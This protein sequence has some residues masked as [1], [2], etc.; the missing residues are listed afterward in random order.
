MGS[1]ADLENNVWRIFMGDDEDKEIHDL[2]KED[3]VL[4]VK[5]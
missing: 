5:C 4:S 1:A 3:M 2:L